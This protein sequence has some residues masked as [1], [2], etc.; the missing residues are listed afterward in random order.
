[1]L[2][3]A[4]WIVPA[5][6]SAGPAVTDPV[7]VTANG[8]YTPL[9]EEVL[10]V[11]TRAG[12]VFVRLRRPDVPAG[13]KVPVILNFTPYDFAGLRGEFDIWE[14]QQYVDNGYAAALADVPGT[15]NSGGCWD[16]LGAKEQ[17]AGYDLVEALGQMEWSNG[18]VAMHGSS[19]AG[20]AAIMTAAAH[21]P[22]LATIATDHALSSAYDVVFG[23][24]VRYSEAD[25]AHFNGAGPTGTVTTLLGGGVLPPG[26][27]LGADGGQ[28]R[29]YADRATQRLCPQTR[30]AAIEH[31]HD[32]TPDFDAF[33]RERDFVRDAWRLAEPAPGTGMQVSSLTM[34][35]WRDPQ[36]KSS[37]RTRWFEAIPSGPFKMLVM[38]RRGHGGAAGALGTK[39]ANL[40]H[41]WFD[42][43]LYGHDTGIEDL[44]P[45]WSLADSWR[46]LGD[47]AQFHEYTTWPPR[48]SDGVRLFLGAPGN[49][50][51]S[52]SLKPPT[53]Q[54]ALGSWTDTGAVTES[55]VLGGRLEV[56]AGAGPSSDFLW[57]ETGP[58][59]HD[60]RIVGAPR[61]V[62]SAST[63]T[64]STQFTPVLFDIGPYDRGSFGWI[65]APCLYP[66][67]PFLDPDD[68]DPAHPEQ[69]P[70][71][72]RACAISRGF[73]NARYKDG[74]E[75][76]RD[77]TP[78]QRYRASIRFLDQD[79]TVAAASEEVPAGHRIGLALMSSNAWWAIPDQQRAT[80]TIFSE[81]GSRSA[82]ILPVVGG[83]K[84]LSEAL[85][86]GSAE[87]QR[88]QR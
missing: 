74:L 11:P 87:S 19:Y 28:G 44:S 56:V 25:P 24:A 46:S 75:E 6:A 69:D 53:A 13:M 48:A 27:P 12:S 9:P 36:L 63:S 79:W 22:H 60:V 21:P 76:G 59:S 86:V 39:V 49:L 52:L 55:E 33:W 77:L 81:P 66:T 88:Q 14:S 72:A 58:L 35:S 51:G 41:A 47:P 84:A 15:G 40:V 64:T 54:G 45:V 31:I 82:L 80:N 65:G 62:L 8:T 38:D 70:T 17:Q 83:R 30:L 85:A 78:G 23:D 5:G 73:L 71:R 43:F 26:D 57:F 1:M 10:Y 16:V 29:T 67:S 34:G 68:V 4:V 32:P 61:L 42:R 18:K 20:S 2:L 7:P 50:T 3:I 37:Q